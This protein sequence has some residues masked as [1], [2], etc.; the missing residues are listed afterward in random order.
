MLDK[1]ES[2]AIV[3]KGAIL[4]ELYPN[5]ALRSMS[6]ID[7]YSELENI[8][9]LHDVLLNEG[10]ASGTIGI[11]NHYEYTKYETVK[12]ELHP[13]L[14]ALNSAYGRKIYSKHFE[15][16]MPVSVAMDI[17]NHTEQIDNHLGAFKL[18]P[19]YHYLYIVM[20]MTNH[21]FGAGTGIR[22]VMDIWI[23]NNRYK[24][25]WNHEKKS[26]LLEKFG[27]TCFE[28]YVVALSNKWFSS[29]PEFLTNNINEGLLTQ[30]E[31]YILESGTYGSFS[32]KTQNELAQNGN[33]A[34]RILYLLK[35][36]FL[37]YSVMKKLYPVLNKAPILLPF[38]WIYRGIDYLI[39]RNREAKR[40]IGVVLK[41]RCDNTQKELFDY[42][43]K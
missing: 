31:D 42:L 6:D 30:F 32:H 27:L 29:S 2:K 10:F 33:I 20:H 23:M 22:S 13:E 3:L 28:K 36:L 9:R 17:W 26:Q 1:T 19:E 37:P 4:R 11:D 14:V 8:E 39:H 40:K 43:L 25:Q 34:R 5:P 15:S 35:A 41:N 12:I 16:N 38:M 7:I 24:N 21:F 18:D